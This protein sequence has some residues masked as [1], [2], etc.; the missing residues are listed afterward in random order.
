MGESEETSLTSFIHPVASAQKLSKAWVETSQ[1][2]ISMKIFGALL[3][4]LKMQIPMKMF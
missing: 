3:E 1:M 2:Q 4:T